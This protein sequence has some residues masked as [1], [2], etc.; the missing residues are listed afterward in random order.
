[1]SEILLIVLNGPILRGFNL[2]ENEHGENFF[3]VQMYQYLRV[4]DCGVFC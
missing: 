3:L 4:L 1:M 2:S